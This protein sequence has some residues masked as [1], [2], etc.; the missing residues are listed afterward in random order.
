MIASRPEGADEAISLSRSS[1]RTSF[2]MKMRS[3]RDRIVLCRSM[4]SCAV[5]RSSYLCKRQQA[6]QL[7]LV[8]GHAPMTVQLH[9]VHAID[10]PKCILHPTC[11]AGRLLFSVPEWREVALRHW[12]QYRAWSRQIALRKMH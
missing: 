4:F 9:P 6:C 2:T 5:F 11:L 7:P 8:H 12:G 3:K 1:V 10:A